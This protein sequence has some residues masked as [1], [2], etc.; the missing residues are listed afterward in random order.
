MTSMPRTREALLEMARELGV[1]IP[2]S[3]SLRALGGAAAVGSLTLS[4]RFVALPMEGCDGLPDG[5]PSEITFR[6]YNRI[7]LGGSALMWF[8]A[9]A[10]EPGGRSG[11]HALWLDQHNLDAYRHLTDS[12]RRSCAQAGSGGHALLLQITHA[13]RFARAGGKRVPAVVH[14]VPDLDRAQGFGE[15]VPLVTD[16]WLMRLADQ[17]VRTAGMALDA[18]FDG[19][20]VK[21]CHGYLVSSTLGAHTRPGTFGGSYE[22]RTRFV[23]EVVQRIRAEYPRGI[24][25]VRLNA[26]DG[27]A[28]PYGWGGGA[29]QDGPDPAEPLQLVADLAALGVQVVSVSAGLPRYDPHLNRPSARYGGSLR[30]SAEHPL[31]GVSRLCGLIGDLQR[32]R[33]TLPMVSAGLAWCGQFMPNVAAGMIEQGRAS[34]VGQGRGTFAYPESVRD[35]LQGRGMDPRKVCVACSLCS[36]L[37]K[38]GGPAGCAVR[39]RAGYGTSKPEQ[40]ANH[41]RAHGH[42]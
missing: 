31:R 17:F 38:A 8:E 40:A 4:N 22:N 19:V 27:L 25:A 5:G 2:W 33:P 21:A 7:A 28:Y 10:V 35:I 11:D 14:R 16:D 18:G 42:G 37:M 12:V 30:E 6:R 15:D 29:E 9:A 36:E 24:V 26:W 34:L 20:D 1:S 39:D 23:R 13:G 3:D 41:G 32:S